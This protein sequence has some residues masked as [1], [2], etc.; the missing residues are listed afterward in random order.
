MQFKNTKIGIIGTL[1][2]GKTLRVVDL[3]YLLW[4]HYNYLIMSNMENLRFQKYYLRDP[5]D[6]LN[7]EPEENKRYLY[8]NNEAYVI[9]DSFGRTKG[10]KKRT[11]QFLMT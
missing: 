8:I 10:V 11:Y 1:G 5:M 2:S 6:L 9:L 7:F 4:H 3:A